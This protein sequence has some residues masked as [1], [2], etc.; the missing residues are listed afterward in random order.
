MLVNKDKM[1]QSVAVETKQIQLVEIKVFQITVELGVLAEVMSQVDNRTKT[2]L[3]ELINQSSPLML[4]N[5]KL[6]LE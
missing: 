4:D 2:Q 1:V 5:L 3:R 6:L